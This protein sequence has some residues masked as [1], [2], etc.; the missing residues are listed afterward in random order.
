MKLITIICIT[1]IILVL[2]LHMNNSNNMKW[3]HKD[4]VQQYDLLVKKYGKPNIEDLNKGG[5]C[6]WRKDKLKSTCFDYI[7]LLDE[8]VPHCVPAPHRDFLYTYVKYEVPVDKILD[9]TSLSGSVAYDP[10]KKSLRA[11]CGSEAANIGT[12]YLATSI[13]NGKI[14]L[15]EIQQKK[16]YK[17]VILSL[18]NK[19]NVALYYDILCT[20][21]KEQPGDPNWSGYY[22]LAF[23]EGCCPGYDPEKNK[24]GEEENFFTDKTDKNE[25][26]TDKTDKNVDD[27]TLEPDII[28]NNKIYKKIIII[29]N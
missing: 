19:Q 18:R 2:A 11:R 21:L 7:E 12:L 13:G 5:I 1:V 3:E 4:A 15:D 14:T 26:F 10:L 25:Q 28:K 16:L 8:S 20:N 9:V 17:E 23:P 6:I 29:N 22:P 24:C 27:P